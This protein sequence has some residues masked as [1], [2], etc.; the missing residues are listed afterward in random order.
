MK[1]NLTHEQADFD[2]IA[3]LLGASILED[4]SLS[5]LPRKANRNVQDFLQ[6]YASDLPF[7]QYEETPKKPIEKVT[8]VDTQSLIT[9]KGLKKDTQILAIDHHQQKSDFPDEWDFIHVESGAATTYFIDQIIEKKHHQLS[10]IEATLLLLGIY[11]DTG[12]LT[13]TNTT[14]QDASAVAF[15]LS[16]GANLTI[17]SRFINP[18]LSPEQQKVFQDLLENAE[19]IKIDGLDVFITHSYA[20]DLK[21]EVSSIAHKIND[22]FDLDALFIF[23]A[24]KEGIR[25]VARSTTNQIDTSRITKFYGGGGHHRASAA[26]IKTDKS[27]MKQLEKI[28]T[29]FIEDLPDYIQPAVTVGKVM[30]KKPLTLEP[31]TT[32]DEAR[33]LM[34]RFGYEGFPVIKDNQIVGLLNRRSIDKAYAHNLKK[35]ASSLMEAGNYHVTPCDSLLHLQQVMA[36]SGWGQVPVIEPT[37]GEIIGIATR[38]DLLK[39][40]ANGDNAQNFLNLAVEIKEKIPTGQYQLLRIISKTASELDIPLYIVGGFVRDIILRKPSPDLD[41]VVEGDAILLAT[42]LSESFGG[43]VTSHKKF[44]TAKWWPL[45]HEH[46]TANSLLSINDVEISQIPETID[47]ISART[48]FYEKPTALPTIKKGSIKLDLHRRDFT[49]NTMAIRLDGAS[50]GD[51][52]DYWGG[53]NDLK[54]RKIKVLHSLSFVDD[55]TRMLRAVRFEQRFNFDIEKRTLELL[56]EAVTLLDEVSGDRIRHEIDQILIEEN[57]SGMLERLHQLKIL[58]Q[59]HSALK[60]DSDLNEDMISLQKTILEDKF[61]DYL[62]FDCQKIIT[63]GKYLVLLCRLAPF[64]LKQVIKR[65]RFNSDTQKLLITANT[66]WHIQESLLNVSPGEFTERLENYHPL[67][68]TINWVIARNKKFKEMLIAFI[69]RWRLIQIAST[70]EELIK[71]NIPPGPIYRSVLKQLRTAKING[72]FSTEKQENDALDDLLSD[73]M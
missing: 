42:K 61:K 12:L 14:A 70:G 63:Q 5:I 16:K 18:P 45:D 62:S 25:L 20:P 46:S 10:I 44:G 65:M 50:F 53:L 6:L 52:Y 66:L 35:T 8:L 58:S 36:E 73:L 11:E 33:L 13:Y 17:A 38:T 9:L 26:L 27:D 49:I 19:S 7:Y 48:E 31:G 39:V 15:L 71:R 21:D 23:V 69:S 1:V 3:S 24:L 47:L 68:V 59:I 43:K 55:P 30:S 67:A 29:Q 22:L 34:E 51:V 37:S 57:V 41:F 40:L 2:A 64:D 32:V 56:F 72:E 60:W 28:I 4:D 54:N